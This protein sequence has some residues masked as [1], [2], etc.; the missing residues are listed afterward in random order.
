MRIAIR[1]A[2]LSLDTDIIV[3]ELAH[4]SIVD[5][6]DLGSLIATETHAG[7]EVHDPEDDGGHHEGVGHARSAV[8]CLVAELDV[9]V[10]EP[11]ASDT[12]GAIVRRNP[13]LGEETSQEVADNTANGV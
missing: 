5:T 11:A 7:D 4:L 6:E 8:G 1:V 9:V 13:G 3:R 2:Q 12:G 10:V